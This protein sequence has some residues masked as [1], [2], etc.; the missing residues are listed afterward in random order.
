MAVKAKNSLRSLLFALSFWT[1][2][3]GGVIYAFMSSTTD[4]STTTSTLI[5][6][7]QKALFAAAAA[8]SWKDTS[9]NLKKGVKPSIRDAQL[10]TPLHLAAANGDK[11]TVK[12]LLSYKNTGWYADANETPL[13]LAARH[14]N[15]EAVKLITRLG[16]H[17]WHTEM[18]S[19]PKAIEKIKQAMGH[20][21]DKY[22]Q[23][24]FERKSFSARELAAI[25]GHKDTALAFPMH[26]YDDLR[27][28]LACA[29]M[30]GNVELVELLWDHHSNRPWTFRHSSLEKQVQSF[31]APPFHLAVMSGNRAVVAFFLEKGLKA[32][33]DSRKTKKC[34]PYASYSSPAHYAAVVGDTKLLEMLQRRGADLTAE[35]YLHRT[36]LS[37]AVENLNEDAVELLVKQK[38]MEEKGW[39]RNSPKL[40]LGSGHVWGEIGSGLASIS[41][42]RIKNAMES[43]KP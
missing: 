17:T 8:G 5:E 13:H 40:F 15:T 34:Y 19:D 28:A 22:L 38:Y 25:Y 36:P 18:A 12:L 35:D 27:H 29:C 24:F 23:G 4:S 11:A 32:T 30:L 20:K 21:F 1:I 43:L 10:R 3:V 7:G 42:S 9:Y 33:T 2:V 41:S 6:P 31:P 14:G 26:S 37:Y 16:G 39:L